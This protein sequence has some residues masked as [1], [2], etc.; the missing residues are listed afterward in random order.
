MKEAMLYLS[1]F[2]ALAFIL[3]GIYLRFKFKDKLDELE[4]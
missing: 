4:K 2:W 3:M 1:I